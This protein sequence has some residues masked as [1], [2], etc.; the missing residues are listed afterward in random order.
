MCETTFCKNEIDQKVD[1]LF[2]PRNKTYIFN[3]NITKQIESSSS[4][5]LSHQPT[6]IDYRYLFSC[7]YYLSNRFIK[8]VGYNIII[9]VSISRC[10]P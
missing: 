6:V 3:S 2:V 7:V 4:S 9:H 8:L 1:N 10:T 5:T